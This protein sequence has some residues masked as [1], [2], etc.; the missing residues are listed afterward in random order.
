MLVDGTFTASYY[1]IIV[2]IRRN[3]RETMKPAIVANSCTNKVTPT[4]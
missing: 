4:D 1:Y 3:I 2:Y